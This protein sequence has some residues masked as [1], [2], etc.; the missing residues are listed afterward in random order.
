M[1]LVLKTHPYAKRIVHLGIW[2]EP[3]VLAKIEYRAKSDGEQS[4]PSIFKGIREVSLMAK[5]AYDRGWEWVEKPA[6]SPLTI[7]AYLHDAGMQLL[8]SG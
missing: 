5:G 7:P 8:G 2:A 4:T 3:S 1:L 6:D